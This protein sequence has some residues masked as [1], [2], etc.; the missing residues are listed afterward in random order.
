MKEKSYARRQAA[1]KARAVASQAWF[2]RFTKLPPGVA[3]MLMLAISAVLW[4]VIVR[5]G[6]MLWRMA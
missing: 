3:I 6:G 2:A 1:P 4:L 5:F